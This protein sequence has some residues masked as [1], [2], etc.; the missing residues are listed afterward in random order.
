MGFNSAF[1]GLIFMYCIY[2]NAFRIASCLAWLLEHRPFNLYFNVAVRLPPE[3]I[4]IPNPT[5]MLLSLP[6]CTR[7]HACVCVCVCVPVCMYVCVCV[8]ICL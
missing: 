7:V 3:K 2:S 5:P 6:S 1:K 8:Y 4:A